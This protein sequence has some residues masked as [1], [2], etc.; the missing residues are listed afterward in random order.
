MLN[1]HSHITRAIRTGLKVFL[2]LAIMPGLVAWDLPF[3]SQRLRGDNDFSEGNYGQAIEHYNLAVRDGGNDWEVLYNLGTSYYENGQWELAVEDLEF[4]SQI[5]SDQGATDLQRARIL[6]NLALSCI[7]LDNCTKAVQMINEAAELAGSD[8]DIVANRAFIEEYCQD[9]PED[10]EESEG[11]EEENVG[12]G[13]E[14]DE[15]EGQNDEG[16]SNDESEVE[17]ESDCEEGEDEGG[18]G[19][20]EEDEDSTEDGENQ[21]ESEESSDEGETEEEQDGQGDQ[22]EQEEQDG[23]GDEQE[24]QQDEGDG[25]DD[26]SDKQEGNQG[27]EEEQDGESGD[28]EEEENQGGNTEETGPRDIPDDGLNMSESQI[29][30]ILEYMRWFERSN[31]PRYFH[32]DAADGDW[33][34]EDSLWDL[35]SRFWSGDASNE[36]F[37]E[38]DDGIDW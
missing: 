14:E 25:Q 32:N 20:S 26:E 31:A 13:D 22:E 16:D 33:I 28:G 19:E 27:D 8:E 3:L 24:D 23:E 7:Q 15:E 37:E 18:S 38:P 35:W 12:E 4:A 5:A 9:D 30:D 6:H 29:D 21:D 17:D 10:A 36:A 1:R 11:E 34:D 2:V